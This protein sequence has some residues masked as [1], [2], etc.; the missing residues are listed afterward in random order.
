MLANPT[1]TT[2]APSLDDGKA[3]L[4]LAG[5]GSVA[6]IKIPEIAK[7]LSRKD[8]LSIRILLTQS[9]K[10]FLAGQSKEQPMASS[11]MH[12]PGVDAV[13]DDD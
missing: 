13:Y 3:H 1:T 4:L 5:S 12:I 9:A 7:A 10:H 11:L 6:I 2:P 8:K